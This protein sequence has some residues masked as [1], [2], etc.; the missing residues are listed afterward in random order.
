MNAVVRFSS[1]VVPNSLSN[2][3]V[4]NDVITPRAMRDDPVARAYRRHAKALRAAALQYVS[5]HD[6][7]DL[8]QDVFVVAIQRRAALPATDAKALSWLIG[9]AKRCA[10]SYGSGDIRFVP[11]D[12]LLAREAGDDLD[13]RAL[14]ED[15]T[16]L[17]ADTWDS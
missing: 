10:S 1:S 6:V 16:E 11:L 3:A 15:V 9:I 12:E 13:G 2:G 7:D 14:H 17:C 8:A 5:K 4:A